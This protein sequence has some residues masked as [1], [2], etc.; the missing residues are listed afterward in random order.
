[1]K[2]HCS[3]VWPQIRNLKTLKRE[4]ETLKNEYEELKKKL[5]GLT[6]AEIINE[7]QS[8]E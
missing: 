3:K 6:T 7:P 2:K 4:L 8:A 5:E 1:M